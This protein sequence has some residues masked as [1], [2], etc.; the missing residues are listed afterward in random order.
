M[1]ERKKVCEESRGERKEE[2]KKSIKTEPKEGK[3]SHGPH[4]PGRSYKHE[5]SRRIHVRPRDKGEFRQNWNSIFSTSKFTCYRGKPEAKFEQRCI[6]VF[7]VIFTQTADVEGNKKKEEVKNEFVGCSRKVNL[8][9]LM[10]IQ[11]EFTGSV[12]NGNI[13]LEESE[14]EVFPFSYIIFSPLKTS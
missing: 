11:N 14:F 3:N 7:I 2:K 4:P 1:W 9:S 10:G 12:H 5:G 6:I 8:W 13:S